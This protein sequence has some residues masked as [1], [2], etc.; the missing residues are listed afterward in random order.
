MR[1]VALALLAVCSLMGG[2]G[3]SDSVDFALP[4][5]CV[6]RSHQLTFSVPSELQASRLPAKL[7]VNVTLPDVGGAPDVALPFGSAPFPALFFFNGFMVCMQ[8]V[9]CV[10]SGSA[11]VTHLPCVQNR[12]GWYHRIIQRVASWGVA[13]V[14]YDTPLL[15]IVTVAAEVQLF[16]HLVEVGAPLRDCSFQLLA[17]NLPANFLDTCSGWPY[18][19]PTQP[20]RCTAR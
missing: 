20:A 15:P 5:P 7:S 19:Q 13:T 1:I 17:P 4:G 9:P 10:V 8:F 14:Q 12:A 16:P 11:L 18:K 2:R 6:P 3:L